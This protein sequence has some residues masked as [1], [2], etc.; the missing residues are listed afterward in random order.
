MKKLAW[1][2]LFLP[3]ISWGQK[4]I[5]YSFL[6][7]PAKLTENANAIIRLDEQ[8]FTIH[9]TGKATLKKK[10]VCTVLNQEGDKHAELRIDYDDLIIVSNISGKLYDR[11]GKVVDKLKKSEIT[12]VNTSNYTEI[13]DSRIKIAKFNYNTYPYTVEFEYE[14]DF[15]SL[16]FYPEFIPC[17]RMYVSIEKASLQILTSKNHQIYYQERNISNKTEIKEE[18]DKKLYTWSVENYPAFKREYYSMNWREQ[19]PWVIISPKEFE[20][21][22]KYKG[23]MDSWESLGMF[24]KELNKNRQE[25]PEATKTKIQEI[26]ANAKDDYEKIKI[27][28]NYMQSKTRYISIQLGVGGWQT[29]P[30]NL[31]DSKGYG[32]CKALSNYT[33]SL[34][35]VVGIESHYALI[36]AGDKNEVFP[37]F[38]DFPSPRFNHAIL[39]VPTQKDTIWLECTSQKMPTGFLGD[40]TDDRYVLLITEK[41]GKLV[42]TPKYTMQDNQLIRKADVIIKETGESKASIKTKYSN[43]EYDEL[44]GYIVASNEEQKKYLYEEMNIA[45]FDIISINLK[46][47]K[48]RK[49]SLEENLEIKIDQIGAK[50]GKRIF[51]TP[52]LF[53]KFSLPLPDYKERKTDI[54]LPFRDFEHNDEIRFN[55]PANFQLEGNFESVNLSSSFGTYSVSLVKEN[56]VLVYKRKLQVKSG[57]YSKEK[58]QEFLDFFRKIDK[59][60]KMKAVLVSQ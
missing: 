9:N 10:Y 27:I 56:S 47:D 19:V 57:R 2:F 1:L 26:T 52:N 12:D 18:K 17:Q 43:L 54:E 16:L 49:P 6:L 40:F 33:K 30:A 51:F 53:N 7:I 8:V 22:N 5:D 60:D 28:Y 45:K 39:C 58:Y 37:V 25:V 15:E 36:N 23:K 35:N 3:T 41:G 55:I 59:Y 42:K 48:S 13:D 11:M 46:E 4:N 44:R 50:N 34:L 31:V 24:F 20:V 38:A 14:M 21:N 32:D 29:M